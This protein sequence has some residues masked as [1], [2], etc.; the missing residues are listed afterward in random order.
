MTIAAVAGAMSDFAEL[1]DK[2]GEVERHTD[3]PSQFE[4]VTEAL[5]LFSDLAM[6][7]D[8]LDEP[9]RDLL[10]HLA[11][12]L[13]DR[14]N[15]WF[16]RQRGK[17]Q[18][19]VLVMRHGVEEVARKALALIEARDRFCSLVMEAEERND[20]KLQAMLSDAVTSSLKPSARTRLPR[21]QI[22]EWVKRLPS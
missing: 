1:K 2:A 13:G 8:K 21:E 9:R 4:M 17:L 14:K 6:E 3:L 19:A 18:A 22:G 10:R 7:W 16:R 12:A 5:D 20:K 15:S 11:H